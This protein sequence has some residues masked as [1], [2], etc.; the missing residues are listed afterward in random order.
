[1]PCYH[2]NRLFEKPTQIN[3]INARSFVAWML[4]AIVLRLGRSEN[5]SKNFKA[6]MNF[7]KAFLPEAM[8]LVSYHRDKLIQRDRHHRELFSI[9]ILISGLRKPQ[10]V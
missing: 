4:S 7:L 2:S 3:L 10:I 9:L 1:M 6:F 5:F 8:E